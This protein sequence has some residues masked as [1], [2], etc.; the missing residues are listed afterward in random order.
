MELLQILGFII[1]VFLGYFVIGPLITEIF[2]S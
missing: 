1:G 2:R